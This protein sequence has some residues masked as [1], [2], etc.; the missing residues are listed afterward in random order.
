M[1]LPLAVEKGTF[2]KLF[3]DQFRKTQNSVEVL[4]REL[5]SK[6][7]QIVTKIIQFMVT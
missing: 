5:G 1:N 7:E 4:K 6:F 3:E 2:K